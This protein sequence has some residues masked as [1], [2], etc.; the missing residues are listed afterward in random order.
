M[1]AILVVAA[2]VIV[3]AGG[4]FNRQFKENVRG[5][6]I[7]PTEAAVATPIPTGDNREKEGCVVS[8]CSGQICVE[9][10]KEVATTC[11]YRNAY[12]CYK[13]GICERQPNGKCGWTMTK[14][15]K[16]CIETL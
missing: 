1:K 15:L 2:G 5:P 13:Q 3:L 4:W 8:G 10:G 11:E 16:D 9:A 7:T 6:Q 12:A 14:T